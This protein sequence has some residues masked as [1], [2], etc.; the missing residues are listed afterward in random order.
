MRAPR[1]YWDRTGDTEAHI[2]L[3]HVIDA[4]GTW[5]IDDFHRV[6]HAAGKTAARY[7]TGMPLPSDGCFV[8]FLPSV[9]GSGGWWATYMDPAASD[10]ALRAVRAAPGAWLPRWCPARSTP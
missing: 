10:D 3:E 5:S 1:C 4:S 8:P 2:W 6:A 9:L 7:L